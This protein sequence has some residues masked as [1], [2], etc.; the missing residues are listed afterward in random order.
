[1]AISKKARAGLR[2]V[3]KGNLNSVKKSAEVLYQFDFLGGQRYAEIVKACNVE[4]K[5]RP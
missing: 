3:S 1:M 4:L 2:N 5:R